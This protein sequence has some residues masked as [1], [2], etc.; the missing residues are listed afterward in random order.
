MKF[1]LLFLL[2]SLILLTH[3]QRRTTA[4]SVTE[5]ESPKPP[6]RGRGRSRFVASPEYSQLRDSSSTTELPSRKTIASR[7]RVVE[8]VEPKFASRASVAP[9]SIPSRRPASSLAE[10]AD[11]IFLNDNVE[12]KPARAGF[13]S[14]T[15][16]RTV[17]KKQK[18]SYEV[19]EIITDDPDPFKKSKKPR[20]YTE[21]NFNYPKRTAEVTESSISSPESPSS[22]NLVD[23]QPDSTLK[24]EPE[25]PIDTLTPT[26]IQSEDI[27]KT[28]TTRPKT[29]EPTRQQSLNRRKVLR[30]KP[31]EPPAPV[32][33]TTRTR[34]RTRPTQRPDYYFQ[35]VSTS[36][37]SSA[38]RRRVDNLFASIEP[39]TGPSV[40]NA[41]STVE[42]RS[43]TGRK[44]DASPDRVTLP[45]PGR[46]RRVT[47][48]RGVETTAAARSRG[49]RFRQREM[50]AFDERKL[51]VLPLFEEEPKVVYR[52]KPSGVATAE[53]VTKT[54][55]PQIR[56]SV[57]SE[58]N[59]VTSR[60]KV[61]RK[62]IIK[63][64]VAPGSRG[65]KKSE[66][67]LEKKQSSEEI[68][69]TDNYPEEFKALIKAKKEHKKPTSTVATPTTR[70]GSVKQNDNK[71]IPSSTTTR[72]P[73]STTT[74][75]SFSSKVPARASTSLPVVPKGSKYFSRSNNSI[76][77]PERS[78]PYKPTNRGRSTFSTKHP[79]TNRS[80]T[81]AFK[82]Y[83]GGT[84]TN[85][86]RYV[87]TIPSAPYVPTVPVVG[88]PGGVARRAYH[89]EDIAGLQVI[90]IDEPVPVHAIRSANL[91]SEDYQ[92]SSSSIPKPLPLVSDG[93]TEKPASIIERIINSITARSTVS[94]SVDAVTKITAST[95]ESPSAILKLAPKRQI[96]STDETRQQTNLVDSIVPTTENPTTIIE[97]ILSSLNAI[98]ATD[99]AGVQVGT[100]FNTLSSF[101]TT[102]LPSVTKSSTGSLLAL[103]S[104]SVVPL[105]ILDEIDPEDILQ[106]Q[107]IGRLLDLLNGLVSTRRTDEVVVTPVNYGTFSSDSTI[108]SAP[109]TI[110]LSTI[111]ATPEVL[112]TVESTTSTAPST[113]T[114]DFVNNLTTLGTESTTIS[115]ESTTLSTEST[116]LSTESPTLSTR[117][118]HFIS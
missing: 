72:R 107:T 68:D 35:S 71:L 116:T 85:A 25:A 56:E 90:S 13:S 73:P 118:D 66:V 88:R 51:E 60:R 70:S 7:R 42:Y 111:T 104:T 67:K 99:I 24:P 46:G 40:F 59:E 54:F 41:D 39:R 29:P 50:P 84:T 79:D 105:S 3:A 106:K 74:S 4:K 43:R 28:S 19:E 81:K 98:Q 110:S 15:P 55:K 38:F 20:V 23:E 6:S 76:S 91:V 100:D 48:P 94:P 49:G 37:P 61:P 80:S 11:K 93:T 69:E 27:Q 12:R 97:K 47:T 112:S 89:Q 96:D 5:P 78:Y 14:R 16:T 103:D 45:I 22:T 83:R 113:T 109:S 2:L 102:P 36:V 53:I 95:T 17:N 101:T 8:N 26:E 86:P 9:K 64:K 10:T 115:S 52:E 57:V 77:K 92:N 18:P 31:Q 117:S 108:S 87:P 21:T 32:S 34:T 114:E 1:L 58:V 75:I 30:K 62:K 44:I 65:T 63:Q 82:K 33:T